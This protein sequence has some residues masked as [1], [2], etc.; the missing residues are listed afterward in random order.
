MVV[1]DDADDEI[2]LKIP[3]AGIEDEC[4]SEEEEEGEDSEDDED[5]DESEEACEEG[6]EAGK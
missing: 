2:V 4:S 5:D 1:D 3:T 6:A